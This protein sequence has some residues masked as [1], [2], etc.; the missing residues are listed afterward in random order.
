M[1]RKL[2]ILH[3]TPV[4]VEPLKELAGELIPG[5]K[6]LNFMDDTILPQLADNGGRLE[7]VEERLCAYA[8]Y[9]EQLGADCILNACSSVGDVV[10]KMRNA[11]A[12][13]VVRI[14]EAMAERAVQMGA[15]IGVAATLNT[16]LQ[17]TLNLLTSKAAEAGKAVHFTPVLAES[18]YRKLVSGDKEGHDTELA[19]ALAGLVQEADA[20]VLAQASMARVVGM[21]PEEARP[22]FLASPR[23]GMERVKQVMDEIAEQDQ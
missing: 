10:S 14:D 7:D 9:A 23:L 13:P 3:T 8:V 20:V 11:V 16:T 5:C 21:L 22:R 18:A 4:T 6:V 12:I 15:K 1:N 19:K 2:A 17:P